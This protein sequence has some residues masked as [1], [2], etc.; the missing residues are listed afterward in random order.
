LNSSQRSIVAGILFAQAIL[1]SIG[2]YAFWQLADGF[3][4]IDEAGG[5]A[6]TNAE[7]FAFASPFIIL[8]SCFLMA[9]VY[10]WRPPVANQVL[11]FGLMKLVGRFALV[12]AIL[13]NTV[14]ISVFL[15]STDYTLDDLV[16][17]VSFSVLLATALYLYAKALKHDFDTPRPEGN[18]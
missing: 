13:T 8:C 1:F 17:G 18:S 14:W 11:R 15:F 7:R 3:G 16:G 12:T 2:A 4:A 9:A 10:T 6:T 5:D